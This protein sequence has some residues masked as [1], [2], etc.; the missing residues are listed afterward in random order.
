[1]KEK[2]HPKYYHSKVTCA[3]GAMYEI[4]STKENIRI[5]ICSAC[6][7]L[8]KGKVKAAATGGRIEKFKKKYAKVKIKAA[9]PPKKKPKKKIKKKKKG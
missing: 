6:H 3:C 1:M 2:I 7:P 9:K 4:G 5:D 8:F